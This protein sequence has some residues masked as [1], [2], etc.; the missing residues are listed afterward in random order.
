MSSLYQS[1]AG[2][3]FIA[4]DWGR[5]VDYHNSTKARL[6]SFEDPANNREANKSLP[7]V[8][9]YVLARIFNQ[10]TPEDRKLVL[11]HKL[12]PIA[13]LPHTTLY[14]KRSGE[15]LDDGAVKS[16]SIIAEIS[17]Q[18][19]ARAI[20]KFLAKNLVEVATNSLRRTSPI[21]SA[22][23]RFNDQQIIC[24]V[25]GLL[26]FVAMAYFLPFAWAANICNAVFA[27]LFAF[28]IFLRLLAIT[29]PEPNRKN[30]PRLTDIDLP[31][32]SVLVPVFKETSVLKQLI[33]ALQQLRYP[34]EKLDIKIIVEE[35]DTKMQL[36]LDAF[37]LPPFME[38]LIV[39]QGKPQTKPRALNYALQFARGELLTIYDAE[40]I[41]EPQQLR[42]AAAAFLAHSPNTAC[43]QGELAFYNS[44]ENWLTRQFAVE[45][46][47]L[48]RV[49][50]PALAKL[51]LPLPLGGTS[52][53]FKT[54]ALRE[55]GG[56]DPYNVTEDADLGIRFARFGFQVSTLPSVT[57]E[58]ANTEV[59]NWLHQRSRW[60]KGF[61]QTWLVHMRQPMLLWQEVGL[62]GFV[63]IQAA[64]LGVVVAATFH[65]IFLALTLFQIY[66]GTLT[67]LS[68]SVFQTTL[69]LL[70]LT[71]MLLGL[72][73]AIISGMLAQ[74]RK[75][76]KIKFW[77]HLSLP[78]YWWLMSIAGW[79]ALWE[80]V[81]APFHWNKTRH[82]ISKFNQP[83]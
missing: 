21:F 29:T 32:F 25:I 22:H 59:R 76:Q 49:I 8:P 51:K 67:D 44:N 74:S 66:Q 47:T 11:R 39:P 34:R 13:W 17:D 24:A 35:K 36:A 27:C 1:W 5:S 61:L 6:H 18:N 33:H 75:G 52:N 4:K 14:A 31:V 40:D 58:E 73:L 68:G 54:Q 79:K 57:Y 64:T 48:F 10:I 60:L 43:L 28:V 80:F 42:I 46:A 12:V 62:F 3:Y 77:T 16:E 78:A 38:V 83:G 9:R 7:Q 41:P 69:N 30:L 71:N 55:V 26:A 20:E 72:V 15:S 19:Y 82:G 2:D 81:V 65:P 63:V 50:L 37:D 23:K 70:F 45:Y 56:W 53:H